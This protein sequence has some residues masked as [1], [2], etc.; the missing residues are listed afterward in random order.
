[1]LLVAALD[2]TVLASIH[3]WGQAFKHARV[4]IFVA[5]ERTERRT[6]LE[7]ELRALLQSKGAKPVALCVVWLQLVG[8]FLLF[9]LSV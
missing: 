5:E 4:A 6:Q 2:A 7:K 9:F 3:A 1:V 8:F